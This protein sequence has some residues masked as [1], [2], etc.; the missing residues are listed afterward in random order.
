MHGLIKEKGPLW[1]TAV[2][3]CIPPPPEVGK[4]AVHASHLVPSVAC[5][6][7][8]AVGLSHALGHRPAAGPFASQVPL[9]YTLGC[10][11]SWRWWRC[12]F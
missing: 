4:E 5:L 6:F 3:L 8:Q 12:L 2:L 7:I 1:H 10:E 9:Y 11:R